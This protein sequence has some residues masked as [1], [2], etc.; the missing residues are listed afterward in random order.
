[1][2]LNKSSSLVEVRHSK[3]N[4]V[5]DWDHAE[6]TFLPFIAR[7]KLFNRKLL[8]LNLRLHVAFLQGLDMFNMLTAT[9]ASILKNN[10]P[11]LS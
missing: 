8:L 6:A 3:R 1:M 4:S 11:L 10:N 9:G 5:L 2:Y 7:I